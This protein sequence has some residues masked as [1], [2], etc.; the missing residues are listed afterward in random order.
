MFDLP[1]MT[2]IVLVAVPAFWIVYTLGFLWLSRNWKHEDKDV[3][4]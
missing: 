3:E 2:T 4:A 1:P